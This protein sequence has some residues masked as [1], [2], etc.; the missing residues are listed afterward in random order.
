MP[1]KP[2]LTDAQMW[3][4]W[5]KDISRIYLETVYAFRSRRNFRE[6]RQIFVNN[7][8]LQNEAGHVWEWIMGMYGR[9]QVL[10]VGREIDRHTEVINLIQLM[11]QVTKRP[12]VI[13]KNRYLRMI[14]RLPEI[15]GQVRNRDLDRRLSE[16][17]FV[18]TFGTGKNIN[19]AVVKRDRNRLEKSAKAVMRYR[20]KVVA[21]RSGLE[22]TLTLS[23][24]DKALD[25][26]E[27]TLKKYY[28][29]FH[30]SSLVGAEPTAQYDWGAPFTYPW[31]EPKPRDVN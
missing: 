11:Y 2:R 17:W 13:T 19:I 9:D 21:H 1:R 27:E 24:I 28:V 8:R 7:R 23:D 20:H 12:K 5:R 10:A 14:K 30:A 22:L 18:D 29:L 6:L 4:K 25:A 26:I 16:T 31:I 3:E 15:P